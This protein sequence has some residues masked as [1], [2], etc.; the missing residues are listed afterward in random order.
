MKVND[1]GAKWTVIR[2]KSGRSKVNTLKQH[3]V[4]SG[5]PRTSLGSLLQKQKM[6][7]SKRFCWSSKQNHI[8]QFKSTVCPLLSERPP[9]FR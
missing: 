9:T 2:Q 6:D 3:I 5:R 1:L 4:N 8:G 7:G